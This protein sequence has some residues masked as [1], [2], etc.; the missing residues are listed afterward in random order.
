[1]KFNESWSR[2]ILNLPCFTHGSPSISPNIKVACLNVR[3]AKF[4]HFEKLRE[5]LSLKTT[6]LAENTSNNGGISPSI[7]T[8]SLLSKY[9]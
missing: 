3:D 7:L 8:F 5:I 4:L 2:L 1:M 9:I 6:F